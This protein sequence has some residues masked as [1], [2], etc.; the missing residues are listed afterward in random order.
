MKVLNYPCFQTVTVG[1]KMSA[2]NLFIF[3][4]QVIYFSSRFE[5]FPFISGVLQLYFKIPK[6]RFLF[7]YIACAQYFSYYCGLLHVIN[8]GK[9][10]NY[11]LFF[12]FIVM[13][14]G[15]LIRFMSQFLILSSIPINPSLVIFSLLSL[16]A[17]TLL[18]P[19]VG[20]WMFF[21]SLS[22]QSSHQMFSHLSKSFQEAFCLFVCFKPYY[23]N[24]YKLHS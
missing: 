2:V 21:S 7:N 19:S 23:F 16:Y 20:Q 4:L 17:A 15:T 11:Y 22:H 1:R 9:L 5:D 13:F 3:P 10:F 8:S 12:I 6:C 14:S 18:L 24:S